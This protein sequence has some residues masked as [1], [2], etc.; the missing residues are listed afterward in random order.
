MNIERPALETAALNI[1]TYGVTSISESCRVFLFRSR[2][3]FVGFYHSRTM[4]NTRHSM[5]LPN[6]E[7]MRPGNL[8]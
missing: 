6:A 4:W 7:Q 5:N 3:G 8:G 2:S 1:R